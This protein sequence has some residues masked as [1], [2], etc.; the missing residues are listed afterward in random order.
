M[1][2]NIVK[3][4]ETFRR[5]YT[6]RNCQTKAPINLTGCAAYSQIREKPGKSPAQTAVCTIDE[7][8][9]KVHVLWS[10]EKT[11]A[12]V[13]G[14]YYFDVWLKSGDEQKPF[15]TEEVEIIER[16]TEI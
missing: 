11:A 3:R 10:K 8:L 13:P 16:I 7:D 9:G 15:V 4:S 6:F 1:K 5:T 14:T 12:L 2:K